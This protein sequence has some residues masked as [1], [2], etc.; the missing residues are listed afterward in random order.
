VQLRAI[1]LHGAEGLALQ[2]VTARQEYPS[3][4][5]FCQQASDCAVGDEC[6]GG[7]CYASGGAIE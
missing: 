4:A 6:R 2:D 1:D 3:S 5:N 7:V